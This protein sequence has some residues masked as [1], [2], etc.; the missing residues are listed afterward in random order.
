RKLR[1]LGAASAAR[2]RARPPLRSGVALHAARPSRRAADELRRA[3][4]HRLP[5]PRLLLWWWSWLRPPLVLPPAGGVS[6][7]TGFPGPLPW[8]RPFLRP[9]RAPAPYRYFNP[10]P[11][12]KTTTRSA[13]RMK[14]L[15]RSS[16][17]AAQAAPPSGQMSR[18]EREASAAA[19][20]P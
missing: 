1:R 5:P 20:R 12:L 16:S 2:L 17:R 8:R 9:P 11:V 7:G 4:Q 6:P 3:A 15:P 19:A 14:P 10:V 13:G 18:P